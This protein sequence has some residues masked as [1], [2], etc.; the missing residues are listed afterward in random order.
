MNN[1]AMLKSLHFNIKS[2]RHSNY[3]LNGDLGGVQDLGNG[4]IAVYTEGPNQNC[5]GEHKVYTPSPIIAG[6]ENSGHGGGDYFTTYYFIRSILGDEVA[7]ERA[8]DVYDA[9]DMCMPGTL[10]YRSIANGNAPIKLP[11][12]RNK[13]ERDAYR[14]DTFCTFPE[15]AGDMYISNNL[16]GDPEIP[17][18]IFEE[19]ERRWNAGEPG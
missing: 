4:Q 8:I 6:T 15:S 12:L 19:V 18:E 17:D 11:N 13:E 3:Q 10:G 1:G 16:W 7:R 9:V 5:R 14:N 2:T